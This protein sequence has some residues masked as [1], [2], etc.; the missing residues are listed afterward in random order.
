[1]ADWLAGWLAG[2]LDEGRTASGSQMKVM[3]VVRG[4][5]TPL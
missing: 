4:R 5:S 2:W 3:L 1:M